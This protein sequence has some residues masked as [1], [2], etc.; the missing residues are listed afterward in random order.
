MTINFC[1]TTAIIIYLRKIMGD[2]GGCRVGAAANQSALAGEVLPA[3]VL[4]CEDTPLL[5]HWTSARQE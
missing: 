1:Y 3:T 4:H 5:E 2:I